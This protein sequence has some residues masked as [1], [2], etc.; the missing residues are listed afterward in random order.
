MDSYDIDHA[1]R[2]KGQMENRITLYPFPPLR[3]ANATDIGHTM[4]LM[5]TKAI[6]DM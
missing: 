6:S 3:D 5:K 4:E 2:N 1:D